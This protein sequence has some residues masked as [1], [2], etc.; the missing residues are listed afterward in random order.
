MERNKTSFDP[1]PATHSQF[2]AFACTSGIMTLSCPAGRTILTVTA[3]YGQYDNPNSECTGCCAPNPLHDCTEL[4]EESRPTDWLGIQLLCD[5]QTSCEFENLG[6]AI[7]QCEEG[8]QS[9]YMQLFY[10]CLPDDETGPVAF[11]AFANTGQPT[12]Y[13][14]DDVIVFNEV[15]SNAGGHY[16]SATSSFICPSHGVYLISVNVQGYD[17]N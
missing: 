15:L 16:N 13:N 10:D 4:V 3:N 1:E 9:D 14:N 7:D 6:S 8:Y 12:W 2:T 11:T 17:S 5:N